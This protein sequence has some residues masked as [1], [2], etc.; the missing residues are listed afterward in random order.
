MPERPRDNGP[1]PG[2]QWPTETRASRHW[3]W[4][5]S[6]YISPRARAVPLSVR[7]TVARYRYFNTRAQ[8]ADDSFTTV[9]PSALRL[10]SQLYSCWRAACA[11]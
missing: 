11:P 9:L 10:Q 3:L 1:P 2:E 7:C 6:C 8:I 4:A 5:L